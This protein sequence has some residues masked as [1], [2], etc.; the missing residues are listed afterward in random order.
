M[1]LSDRVLF[2]D[3]E[4][5]IIDKPAGLPVDTP[6]DKS[7]S[8]ESHLGLLTFGFL[9]WVVRGATSGAASSCR[10]T[11]INRLPAGWWCMPRSTAAGIS[12]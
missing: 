10:A 1:L 3:G 7:V 5:I 6:R 2:L 8:V 12:N 11:C 9:W 4:A